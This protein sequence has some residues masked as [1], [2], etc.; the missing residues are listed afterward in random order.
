MTSA[1][2]ALLVVV[3]LMGGALLGLALQSVL[4]QHHLDSASKDVVCLASGVTASVAA[5]V[6]GL[7]IAAANGSFNTQSQEVETAA[8]RIIQLDNTL[9]L[10][11]PETGRARG[12]LRDV[13]DN[14]VAQIWHEDLPPTGEKPV[15]RFGGTGNSLLRALHELAPAD[16]AQHT[17]KTQAL[18]VAGELMQT[19]LLLFEQA[20]NALPVPLLVMLVGWLTAIFASFGLFAPRNA[21][22]IAAL[23]VAALADAAAVFLMYEL[24]S[25]FSGLLQVSSAPLRSALAP[26]G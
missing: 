20:S 15:Y 12:L 14:A 5:L 26:L 7:L 24:N 13:V 19:R 9:A 22:V 1:A 2:V 21:T 18:A 23:L 10:Y 4:P 17:L 6:L 3:C 25:P 11:G 8:A 16:E